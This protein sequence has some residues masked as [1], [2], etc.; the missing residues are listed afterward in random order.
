MPHSRYFCNAMGESLVFLLVNL[1]VAAVAAFR[2]AFLAHHCKSFRNMAGEYKKLAIK[3]FAKVQ[4]R[5]TPEARYWRQFGGPTVRN[6]CI[7]LLVSA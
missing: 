7:F 4:E 5:D 1:C 2:T 3:Q 6:G